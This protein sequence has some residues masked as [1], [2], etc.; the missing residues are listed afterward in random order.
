[1][2]FLSPTERPLRQAAAV[3]SPLD[4]LQTVS[5]LR[6]GAGLLLLLYFG[7]PA[8]MRGYPY[9]WSG[10]PWE[11]VEVCKAAGIPGMLAPVAGGITFIVS[12]SWTLGFLTRL[13]SAIFLPVV[14]GAVVVTETL[15]ATPY[16][17]FCYLLLF[18]TITLMLFGSGQVSVDQLFKLVD[19]PKK[20][21]G[22]FT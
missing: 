9:V 12:L 7:F 13:F 22:M 10:A 5:I 6:F 17:P 3:S 1:M 18:V 4:A 20:K 2:G 14:I 11:W 21:R 16:Q 19:R 15:N 8:L